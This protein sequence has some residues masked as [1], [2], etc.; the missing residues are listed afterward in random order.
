MLL[1][2]IFALTRYLFQY[3]TT[4]SFDWA[5]FR[6]KNPWAWPMVPCFVTRYGSFIAMIP[7]IMQINAFNINCSHLWP[8]IIV[9]VRLQKLGAEVL[10]SLRA[11]ALWEYNWYIAGF[12]STLWLAT[13]VIGLLGIMSANWIRFPSPAPGLAPSCIPIKWAWEL[14]E[15]R[16]KI[17]WLSEIC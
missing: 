5:I 1:V 17:Q 11:M 6:G 8:A 9:G 15:W 14:G 10:F 4:F 16:I 7:L 12:V 13:A 3:A 2:L